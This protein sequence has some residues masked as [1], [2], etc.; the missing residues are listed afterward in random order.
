MRALLAIRC[1]EVRFGAVEAVRGVG[2]SGLSIDEGEVLGPVGE[3][4]FGKSATAL[5]IMRL[6]VPAL[7]AGRVRPLAVAEA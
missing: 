2:L 4:G 3:S 5:A 7:G 6:L 1:L